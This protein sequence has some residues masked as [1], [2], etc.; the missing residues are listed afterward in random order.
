MLFI[1]SSTDVLAKFFNVS[2][3][4]V[5]VAMRY[6]TVIV[7]I[8]AFP[9]TYRICHELQAAQGRRSTKD[10]E[11]RRRSS[12]GEY[13]ATPSPRYVDDVPSHL[14]ATAVPTYI[15]EESDEVGRQRRARR[16]SLDDHRSTDVPRCEAP[17]ANVRFPHSSQSRRTVAFA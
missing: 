8:L 14:A 3:N 13:T 1:A 17:S 7:P 12:E 9:I 16:R 4:T 6:L 11:R 5:L 2:L 10:A 15:H